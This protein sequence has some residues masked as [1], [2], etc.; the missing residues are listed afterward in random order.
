[1]IGVK[2]V[3]TWMASP[4][5]QRTLSFLG[6]AFVVCVSAAWQL[7]EHFNQRDAV[8]S[9]STATANQSGIAATRDI[10]ATASAG[11]TAIIATGPVNLNA[12]PAEDPVA[13]I[14]H[15]EH[16]WRQAAAALDHND[17]AT[18][19]AAYQ[20]SVT[21][22][23][24]TFGPESTQLARALSAEAWFYYNNDPT[25]RDRVEPLLQRS[26]AMREKV[27]APDD[28]DLAASLSS[29]GHYYMA[30]DRAQDALPLLRRAYDIQA[31]DIVARFGGDRMP[32][33]R[34][35]LVDAYRHL[36]RYAEA[37]ALY[38]QAIPLL[39]RT[40]PVGSAGIELPLALHA[41]ARLY[42]AD[43]KPEDAARYYR[44]AFDLYVT[45]HLADRA[46]DVL[47]DYGPLLTTLGRSGETRALE[48]RLRHP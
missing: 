36:H 32:D 19:E 30:L 40:E 24:T 28:T 26:L 46:H 48:A 5:R 7:Y 16:L 29:L 18:A 10:M 12:M 14:H 27:L 2:R 17:K 3:W 45:K 8:V 43:D 13:A 41:L 38:E 22:M 33:V 11:G 31:A 6:G 23:Q 20:Q 9:T 42:Q 4:S 39:T 25:R 35:D 37:E 47:D 15:M 34:D 1:M 44:L 21:L